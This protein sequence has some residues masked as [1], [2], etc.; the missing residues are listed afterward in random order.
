MNLLDIIKA[1]LIE[2]DRGTADDTVAMYADK[3]TAYANE[4]VNE[5]TRRF[6]LVRVDPYVTD[7][8]DPNG[9]AGFN[10][11]E[12][13]RPVKRIVRVLPAAFGEPL[14][15]EDDPPIIAT[16]NTLKRPW[17]FLQQIHGT[18]W[19]IIP[20]KRCKPG[21]PVF[22]EYKYVPA[23]M[24]SASLIPTGTPPVATPDEPELPEHLHHLIP[25]YVR[26][27]EQ[28]GQDPSTQGTSS[29]FF[30]LFNQMVY[31]LQRETMGSPESFRLIG[32]HFL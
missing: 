13:E 27:R 7:E 31:N 19:F 22:I 6:K 29:A 20:D 25:I 17:P 8:G 3:F 18:P 1:T 9:H 2:L 11:N 12:L 15:P 16:E 28:A 32:Y 24:S 26:A 5:I 23:P 21:D 14:T 30:S 10:A 4:A